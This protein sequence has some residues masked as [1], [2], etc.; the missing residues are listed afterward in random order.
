MLTI[1]KLTETYITLKGENKFVISMSNDTSGRK[2]LMEVLSDNNSLHLW[3]SHIH[4]VW[5]DSS[6]VLDSSEIYN[7]DFNETVRYKQAKIKSWCN[8]QIVK[9]ISIDLGLLD[10]EGNSLGELHYSL[11][12]RH[13]ID[14]RDL[15]TMIS[16]GAQVVTWRDDSRVSHMVY[17]ADQ[18]MSLYNSAM[19]YILQCRF[20]SDALEEL[21]FSYTEDQID[22]VNEL[23]WDTELP[24]AIEDKMNDLLSTMYTASS[25]L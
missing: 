18:F 16:Q 11:P 9:G 17:T 19:L 4:P 20:R 24:S 7:S 13:Q 12:D 1:L 6:T 25:A 22:L 14:M 2:R 3:D 5:G 10:D 21:L 8:S 23:S 15:A